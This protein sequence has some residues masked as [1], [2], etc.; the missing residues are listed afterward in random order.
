M[1]DLRY[2]KT[3]IAILRAIEVLLQNK[4]FEKISI[5]DICEAA[6]ISRSAFYLHYTD[7]YDLA[8]QCQLE[9]IEKGN[10][11][12]KESVI[13]KRRELM[14]TMLNLL[15][16]EGRVLALLISS[17]GSSEIQDNI[18]YL[19]R[20]NARENILPLTN[21]KFENATE[22]RYF[23]SFFS[24]ALFGVIQEWI[25]SGQKETP[26]EIVAFVDKNFLF[27]FE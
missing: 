13:V 7:K 11:L 19:M 3:K 16:G 17:H 23:L 9:L 5:K 8:K 14:L 20:E 24:N 26:E 22:E 4:D 12:I 27:E 15:L 18:R 2:Q 1:M 6:Q 21:L 25:N 10:R